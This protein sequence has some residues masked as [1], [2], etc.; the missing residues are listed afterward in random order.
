MKDDEYFAHDPAGEAGTGQPAPAAPV[1]AGAAEQAASPA[2]ATSE[3]GEGAEPESERTAEL[4]DADGGEPAASDTPGHTEGEAGSEP[5]ASEGDAGNPAWLRNPWVWV[6]VLALVLALVVGAVTWS[7]SNASDAQKDAVTRVVTGYYD[8]LA[9]GKAQA[10]LDFGANPP[11]QGG[12]LSD[13]ALQASQKAAPLTDVRVG[14]IELNAAGDQAVAQVSYKL[15]DRPVDT[16][17]GLSTTGGTWELADVTGELAVSPT[18][19]LVNGQAVTQTLNQVFP[20]TY[21][22]TAANDKVTVTGDPVV[23]TDPGAATARLSPTL[24]LSQRGTDAAKAAGQAA[25]KACF[26]TH[27]S[28]PQ[29]CPWRISG[30]VTPGSVQYTLTNDPWAGFKPELDA[31]RLTASG[32]VRLDVSV[33][34]KT[35]V[36]GQ[37][38]DTTTKFSTTTPLTVDLK[39][40]NP[41]ARWGNS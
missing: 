2:S 24:A 38:A 27:Q 25:L 12:L 10:A 31:D 26:D 28:A 16:R 14:D 35:T 3:E 30:T 40:A 36:N 11:A 18:S 20:G 15:G 9:S 34:A 32:P 17:L 5:A 23:V 8:A 33:A 39:P 4:P 1:D 22:A 7:R 41:A 13:A 21:A 6:G 19:V 29:G 37:P